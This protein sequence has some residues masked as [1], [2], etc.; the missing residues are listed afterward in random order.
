MGDWD[1]DARLEMHRP[2]MEF[3]HCWLLTLVALA[4]RADRRRAIA[5]V[6]IE[7][8]QRAFRRRWGLDLMIDDGFHGL[9]GLH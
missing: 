1:V 5:F 6:M 3:V 4:S 9:T 2:L 8:R 7:G